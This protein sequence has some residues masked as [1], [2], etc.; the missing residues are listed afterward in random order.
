M[1][2]L[3]LFESS[4]ALRGGIAA[5]AVTHKIAIAAGRQCRPRQFST[6]ETAFVH[7]INFPPQPQRRG[8]SDYSPSSVSPTCGDSNTSNRSDVVW[9][10]DDRESE[11]QQ[12]K[13]R[14]GP[15]HAMSQPLFGHDRKDALSSEN[16]EYRLHQDIFEGR[17]TRF[18]SR[19]MYDGTNYSGFQLQSNGQPTVQEVLEVALARRFQQHVPVMGAG[20]TDSG[21]HATGQAI[22]FDLPN[23]D[24]D[25]GELTYVMNQMM[26][27]D[28]R[29]WN[30]SLAPPCTAEQADKR[31]PWHVML[32]ASGKVYSYRLCVGDVPNPLDRLYRVHANRAARARINVGLIY[33]VMPRFVGNHDFAGF[34]NDADKKAAHK[35]A[36]GFGKFNTWR[37]VYSADVVDEGGGNLKLVFHL[38]GALY[39]MVRNMVGTVLSVAAGRV[40]S[41]VVD[42]IFRTGVRDTSKIYC[43]PP[44]GLTL[45]NVIYDGYE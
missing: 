33:E 4:Y 17:K 35:L 15:Q 20:R 7:L 11:L 27:E 8:R 40:G 2:S 13:K 22:H 26:P 23:A 21:V 42:E 19:V 10:D 3:S 18:V 24:T 41:E 9:K 39:R 6:R 1:L 16:G 31:L 12:E 37:E 34:A 32:N 29:V 38:D 36:G 44:H 43:A 28:V 14:H 5:L 45:E 25:L 30:M